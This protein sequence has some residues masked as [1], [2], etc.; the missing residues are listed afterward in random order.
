M[1]LSG[2]LLTQLDPKKARIELAR[3]NLIDFTQY[4]WPQFQPTSFHVNYYSVL[5][6]FAKKLIKRLIVTVPPQHGKSQGSSKYMP[7]YIYG[8]NPDARIALMSYSATF[9]RKFNRHLQRLMDTPEYKE[10][11]PETSLNE[12]NVATVARGYLRNSDEFEIIGHEGSFK[13]IGR[14]GSLTGNPVDI[15]IFDDL[16]KDSMEGNSPII[17][18]AV[19]E[20]YKSVAETRLHNDSQELCVFTR[21]HEDDLI[22]WF[23]KNFNVVTLNSLEDIHKVKNWDDTWIKINFEAIKESPPTPLDPREI[24][25][26]LFPQRHSL[27]KL[28]QKRKNDPMLFDCMYQG[29]PNTKE[30][31]LYSSFK[32]YS[33][34][35]AP[36]NIIKVHNYT[37]TADAGECYL[38]SIDYIVDRESNIY[39][40]DMVYTQEGMEQTEVSIPLM[41]QRDKTRTAYIESNNGGKGFARTIQKSVTY[42]TIE[43]FNQGGN[44]ESRILTNSAQVNRYIHFP[45]DWKNRFPVFYQH[46]TTYKKI[47]KANKFHDGP[48]VMTGIIEKEIIENFDD[49]GIR[50]K[51]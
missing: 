32:T 34:L 10:V 9:A 46:V 42:C 39:V 29:Q 14:K 43:W 28:Q 51:N 50:R 19:I 22:G 11:F 17:R 15:M 21:W 23:E 47:Y 7:A 38:C 40:I 30:G 2:K 31:L 20:M 48:D 44:K 16:Y 36:G 13:S 1:Q 41:L 27:S 18:D 37:D 24:G 49:F 25:E 26:P 35:P 33:Q 3:R 5:D 4:L 8:L 6:A 12:S 45:V